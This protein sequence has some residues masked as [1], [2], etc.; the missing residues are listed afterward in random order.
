METQHIRLV[1]SVAKHK[2]ISAAARDLGMTQPSLT[3]IVSRVED[4]VGLKLF[5]RGPRG[6]TLTQFGD[7]FLERMT[8]VEREMTNLASEVRAIKTGMSGSI[9]IG[10]GQFWIWHALP[11]VLSEIAADNSELKIKVSTG[12]RD[13]LLRGLRESQFDLVLARVDEDLLE[14]MVGEELAQVRM[15][16]VAREGHPLASAESV[17]IDALEHYGWILP[18]GLNSTVRYAFSEVGVEPPSPKVETVIGNLVFSMLRSTDLVTIIPEIGN[19][20]APAGL[21][22]LNADWLKW[23]CS[24]GI[25]RDADRT[26]LPCCDYFVGKMRAYSKSV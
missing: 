22:G 9:S 4:V 21:C 20:P 26:L 17:G 12:S 13:E 25:I 2:N 3:K 15:R 8:R 6:V 19:R 23:R 5:D 18:P 1:R 11:T 14:G 16:L 24:V 7:Y 10:A